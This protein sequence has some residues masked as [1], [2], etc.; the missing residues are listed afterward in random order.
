LTASIES[1]LT[2][3]TVKRWHRLAFNACAGFFFFLAGSRLVMTILPLASVPMP[4]RFV[5]AW[6]SP[7]HLADGYGL[8]A[9]MTTSRP[10]IVFEGSND[11]VNWLAYEFRYKPGDDLRRPPPWVEPHM[12]RL[13]WRLWFAAMEPCQANP[14]VFA[15]VKRMLEGSPPVM[16]FF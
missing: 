8:F 7:F 15:L 10:E 4:V 5:Q 12:P 16:P 2:P 11:G 3:V 1:C 13:D 6:L 9:V 14:W